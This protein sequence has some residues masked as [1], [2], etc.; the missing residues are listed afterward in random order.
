MAESIEFREDDEDA[1]IWQFESSGDIQ[2]SHFMQLLIIW[3]SNKFLP[4]WSG[5]LLS[6]VG[7]TFFYGCLLTT[8]S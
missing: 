7:S 2:F 6:L 1:I 4:R 3:G 8:K 5:K